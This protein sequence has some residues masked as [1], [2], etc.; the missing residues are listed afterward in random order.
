MLTSD[1]DNEPHSAEHQLLDEPEDTET[2]IEHLISRADK[3][4]SKRKCSRCL[5]CAL[6]L[7]HKL[8]LQGSMFTSLYTAYKFV[9]TLSCTQVSC[10]RV[11]SILK[12]VKNRLRSQLSQDILE[13]LM[14]FYVNRDFDFDYERVI[15]D[16]ASTSNHLSRYLKL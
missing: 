7:L 16:V 14:L 13:S 4:D 5:V 12:I 1:D 9:L 6:E 10:E 11:F 15:D 3:C 8:E 2:L